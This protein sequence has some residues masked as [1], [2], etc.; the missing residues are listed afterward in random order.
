MALAVRE[1]SAVF[2][3]FFPFQIEPARLMG[4]LVPAALLTAV[5][6]ATTLAARGEFSIVIPSLGAGLADAS[7]WVLRPPGSCCSP[8]WSVSS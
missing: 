4:A 8:P 2:F 3:V 1:S 7:A 6:I 5:G